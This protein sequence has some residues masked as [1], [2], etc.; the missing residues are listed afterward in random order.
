MSERIRPAGPKDVKALHALIES[1]YRGDSARRGWT[2]EADLLGGQRTDVESLSALLAMPGQTVLL[3]ETDQ[4]L[5]GCVNVADLGERAY[6]GMLSVDPARQAS[7]LGRRL[8]AEAEAL[9][10]L[11]GARVMEMTVIPRRV[12]LIA[13][14]ERRGYHLTGRRAPFPMHDPRFGI[15]LCDHLEFVVLEKRLDRPSAG[16]TPR[17]TPPA[18]E[19]GLRPSPAGP[20]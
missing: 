6:L 3:A 10:R 9:A 11:Q 17:W 1:A 2:H 4:G 18:P 16:V 5:A 14:Y 15:P 12:E 7:G 13:W 19:P 20:G 8:I